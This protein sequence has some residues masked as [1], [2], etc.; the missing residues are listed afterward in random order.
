MASL[1]LELTE[2][3][4][5]LRDAVQRLLADVEQPDWH[6]LTGQ[7]GL[8]GLTLPETAGGFGGGV[9]EVAVVMAD[10]G[11]ALA[12]TDWLSHA[13]AGA[14]L[15]AIAPDFA[16]LDALASGAARA[17]L[18]S[19]ATAQGAPE[20]VGGARLEGT[21]RLVAGGAGADVYVIATGA[22]LAVVRA[23]A[24]GLTRE[25]RALHDGTL[26]ADLHFAGVVPDVVATRNSAPLLDL[27]RAGRCAEAIGLMQRM[28]ADT[29]DYLTQRR[30]FGAPIASFQALRHR[31]A[32]M[33]LAA[34]QAAALTEQAVTALASDEDDSAVS[35]AAACVAVRD[36][37]RVVGEGAVQLH[38]AMGLTEE[39][40]LGARFKR[41][42]AIAAGL[43]S[44][45]EV[46][47]RFAAAA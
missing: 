40:R 15:A 19:A 31:L 39:L 43:G 36:A 8:G 37:A 17:A 13:A 6:A 27:V 33:Q 44:E 12:G 35:L 29:A 46:L 23:A 42:L 45:T 9:A 34:L 11:P 41:V 14:A 24:Q 30:Q 47:E 32:D 10:L 4:Q 7:L 2:P 25:D 1:D 38:G 20:L 5:M 26:A 16:M 3:Q 18:V 22:S 28:L 21:A